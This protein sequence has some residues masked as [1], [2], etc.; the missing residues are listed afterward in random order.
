MKLSIIA[1]P[2]A[3]CALCAAA[4]AA[5][6][7]ATGIFI[8]QTP[9]ITGNLFFSFQKKFFV[10]FKFRIYFFLLVCNHYILRVYPIANLITCMPQRAAG[11]FK[12]CSSNK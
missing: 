12:S 1:A 3:L 10:R 6:I 11:P 7:A 4:T 9:Y 8:G 5:V 2:F